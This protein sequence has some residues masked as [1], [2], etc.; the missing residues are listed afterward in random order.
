MAISNIINRNTVKLDTNI[1]GYYID[2]KGD[3]QK[4]ENMIQVVGGADGVD[5]LPISGSFFSVEEVIG[6]GDVD[7]VVSYKG[8]GILY[9]KS[10]R[11]YAH[12]GQMVL[13]D[14]Q[15]NQNTLSGISSKSNSINERK[16]L[17]TYL[18]D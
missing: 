5:A 8:H 12:K 2:T 4:I 18:K 6:L 15:G 17:D 13:R 3:E 14:G 11:P 10:G 9:D 1:D 16:N 7:T